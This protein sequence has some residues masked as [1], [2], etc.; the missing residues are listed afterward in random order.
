MYIADKDR[1][2]RV[3]Y[4]FTNTNSRMIRLGCCTNKPTECYS[5]ASRKIKNKTIVLLTV[6][7]FLWSNIYGGTFRGKLVSFMTFDKVFGFAYCA[8][9]ITRTRINGILPKSS[10]NVKS[11]LTVNCHVE[12]DWH[13][14]LY[15]QKKNIDCWIV[16]TNCS[17]PSHNELSPGK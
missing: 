2:H 6:Y 4:A 10:I 3:K 14:T 1:Q 7:R 16:V 13:R 5:T 9:M 8:M 15:L 11:K 12:V 17:G